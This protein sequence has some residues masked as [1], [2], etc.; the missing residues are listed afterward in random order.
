MITRWVVLAVL[1]AAGI[2]LLLGTIG[3]AV[4]AA[5]ERVAPGLEPDACTGS[6]SARLSTPGTS[7]WSP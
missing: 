4:T 1:T 3:R 2:P 7:C 6:R 5:G